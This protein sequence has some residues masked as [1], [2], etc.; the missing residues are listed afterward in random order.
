MK[1]FQKTGALQKFLYSSFRAIGYVITFGLAACLILVW[2][3]TAPLIRCGVYLSDRYHARFEPKMQG[4]TPLYQRSSKPDHG[5]VGGP[6][7]LPR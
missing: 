7:R 1:D 3:L 6:V 2:V 5:V 4:N